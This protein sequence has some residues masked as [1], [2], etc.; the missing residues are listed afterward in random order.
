M[1]LGPVGTPGAHVPIEVDHGNAHANAEGAHDGVGIPADPACIGQ[2][3]HALK[4]C[5][6]SGTV[7]ALTSKLKGPTLTEQSMKGTVIRQLKL[8]TPK[9]V[10]TVSSIGLALGNPILC[11]LN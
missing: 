10:H 9:E 6:L 5:I 3:P 2:I 4:V 11:T 7:R 1:A 8:F